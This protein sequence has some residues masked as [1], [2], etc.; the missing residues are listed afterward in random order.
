VTGADQQ[1]DRA[2][3]RNRPVSAFFASARATSADDGWLT[4]PS[5]G[6]S[7]SAVAASTDCTAVT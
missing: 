2:R 3:P 1:H 4:L 7:G 6:C 5:L